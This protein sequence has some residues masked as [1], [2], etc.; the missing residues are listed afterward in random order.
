MV[1]VFE[2]ALVSLFS[3]DASSLDETMMLLVKEVIE[4]LDIVLLSKKA[5]EDFDFI[6][7]LSCDCARILD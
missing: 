7:S 3:I 2:K 6:L 5:I 1:K 4:T